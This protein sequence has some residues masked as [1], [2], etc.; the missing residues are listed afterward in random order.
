VSGRDDVR[1]DN[2]PLPP[3][4]A[5]IPTIDATGDIDQAMQELITTLYASTWTEPDHDPDA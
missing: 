5:A 3:E 4:L 2:A 1:F